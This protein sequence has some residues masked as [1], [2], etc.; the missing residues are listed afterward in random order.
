MRN[1]RGRDANMRFL[2]GSVL[3]FFMIIM[4]VMLFVY[5]VLEQSVTKEDRV[6]D[7]YEISFSKQFDGLEY[8]FYLNDSL[9]Y[10]GRPVSSDTVI[11]IERSLDENS[12]L[13]VDKATDIVSVVEIGRRGRL[14]IGFGRGGEITADLVE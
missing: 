10:V 2:F 11:R 7:C 9:L 12:L 4:S 1:T 5:F 13:V 8:D 14:L 6:R 3:F